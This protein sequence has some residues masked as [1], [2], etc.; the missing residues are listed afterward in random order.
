MC[1]FAIATVLM[2]FDQVVREQCQQMNTTWKSRDLNL[3]EGSPIIK[4]FHC[5]KQHHSISVASSPFSSLPGRLRIPSLGPPQFLYSLM[6]ASIRA[7]ITVFGSFC[8]SLSPSLFLS[9]LLG[10]ELLEGSDHVYPHCPIQCLPHRGHS[11]N[12]SRMNRLVY[13]GAGREHL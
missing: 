12:M 1:L 13:E 3:N 7:I 8:A 6:L 4:L 2:I 10:C 9:L 11:V 5:E